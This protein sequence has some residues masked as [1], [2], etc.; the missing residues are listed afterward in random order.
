MSASLHV[1]IGS[2]FSGQPGPFSLGAPGALAS[3]LERVGFSEVQTRTVSAPLRLA[4]ARECVR[5][6]RE[7]FGAL[8][9]MLAALTET[10][11]TEAW[12]EVERELGKY[13]GHD[14]FESPCEIV[15]VTAVKE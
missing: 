1:R 6:E 10:A 7:A 8:H 4:S 13:E 11:R 15:I 2:I 5:F 9:Q 3:A 12:Q 14:G